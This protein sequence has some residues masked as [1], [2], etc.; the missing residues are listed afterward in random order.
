MP[1]AEISVSVSLSTGK[2]FS[3]FTLPTHDCTKSLL[4]LPVRCFSSDRSNRSLS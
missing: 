4:I 1:Q 3:T 2:P